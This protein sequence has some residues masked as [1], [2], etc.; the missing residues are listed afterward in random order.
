[1][2]DRISLFFINKGFSGNL[3]Q[4]GSSFWRGKSRTDFGLEILQIT[5][6]YIA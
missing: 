2:I 6:H 3:F 1:M 5:V 4:S